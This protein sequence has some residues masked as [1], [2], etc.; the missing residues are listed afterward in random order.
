[1]NLKLSSL[2]IIHQDRLHSSQLQKDFETQ[3]GNKVHLYFSTYPGKMPSSINIGIEPIYNLTSLLLQMMML[4]CIR[5]LK[6]S[7]FFQLNA[8]DGIGGR[9]L[10]IYNE[11]V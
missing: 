5:W 1:M 7:K 8:C 3:F 2:I 4:F 10:L 9:V 11:D 6:I